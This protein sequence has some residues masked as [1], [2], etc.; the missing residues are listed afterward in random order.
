MLV[1]EQGLRSFLRFFDR[2]VLFLHCVASK[3]NARDVCARALS[4]HPRKIR[5]SF[6]TAATWKGKHHHCD[7]SYVQHLAVYRILSHIPFHLISMTIL[8]SR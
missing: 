5:G 4:I 3:I 6:S 7:L 1:E 8:G 2:V